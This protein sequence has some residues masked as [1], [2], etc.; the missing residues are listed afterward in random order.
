VDTAVETL[1]SG[2]VASG[3]AQR[4]IRARVWAPLLVAAVVAACLTFIRLPY[5]AYRPGNVNAL[6][7]RIV[8]TVG[9]RFEPNGEIFFTTVR[10]DSSVNGWEYIEAFFDDDIVL[11]G[12][13]AVLGERSR[14]ENKSF[15][16]D[17]MQVSKSTA[18]AVA[19]RHLGIDPYEATGVG[20]AGVEGPAEGLLTTDDVIVAVDGVP[21]LAAGELVDEIRSRSPGQVVSLGVESIDG[22]SSRTVEVVLGARAEDLTMAFLGVMVQTRWEDVENLPVDVRIETGSVGGNSAGLALTLAILELVTPGEMTGGLKVATTGTIDFDGV[23]GPIGGLAQKTVAAREG[24]VDLFL[25]PEGE[26]EIAARHAGDLHVEPVATLED[27][28]D[29]LAGLGG[30]AGEL[31]LP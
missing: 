18:V 2:P 22:T 17:L 5:F 19:F 30:N 16:L 9:D 15:N 1:P 21:V 26:Y 20:M 10:Q 25:V 14:D 4:R 24:G 8:V 6:T 12:E 7:G 28:L 3:G 31:A 11:Y 29:I 13:G 23:V 27:A